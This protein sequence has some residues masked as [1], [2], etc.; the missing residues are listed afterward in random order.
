ME[1]VRY[2][3]TTC[4]EEHEGLPDLSFASP[5]HFGTVPEAERAKRAIL[6]SD[7]CVIDDG[8]FFV[9]VCLPIPIRG[10]PLNGKGQTM[11]VEGSSEA[12]HRRARW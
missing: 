8:D 11:V 7:T 3:C 4:G 9:R 10:T 1:I 6:T 2:K 12:R 5:F